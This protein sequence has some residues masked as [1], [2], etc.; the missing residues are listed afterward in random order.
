[1]TFGGI[2]FGVPPVFIL[3]L[4]GVPLGLVLARSEKP[5]LAFVGSVLPHGVFELPATILAGAFGLLLGV[6]AIGLIWLWMKGEGEAPTRILMADLRKVLSSFVLVVALLAV[7]AGV[8]TF[9]FLIY[10]GSP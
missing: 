1:M 2:V 3:L 4:N 9:L 10:V 5:I 6:D 7:A 8:E